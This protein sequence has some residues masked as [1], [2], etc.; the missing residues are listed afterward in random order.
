MPNRTGVS[1]RDF[2][3]LAAAMPLAARSLAA[4]A[5]A[6]PVGLELYSVRNELMKD[7]P[8]TVR[9]VAGM[10][11]QVVEFYSPYFD[12]TPAAAKDVRGLLDDLGIRCL[13]THNGPASFTPE[14]LEKAIALNQAIGSRTIVLASSP[15]MTGL[16]SWKALGE[17]M[18]RVMETLRPLGMT[19]GFHN[20]QTEWAGAVGQRPMDVLAAATPQDFVLQFDVGTCVEAGQDPVAWIK[21]HP[22]RIRSLHCKDWGGAARG[23][24]VAFGEGVVPWPAVLDAARTTGGAEYFLIEQEIAGADGEFAMVEKCLANWQRLHG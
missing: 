7:L 16:D 3:A 6:Q 15:R 5:G 21:A 1:R 18:T 24:A 13:S 12:W 11:Y 22:G 2:L 17:Q 14:G 23:Y 4:Q 20:H 9:R 8:G 10:G 19:A